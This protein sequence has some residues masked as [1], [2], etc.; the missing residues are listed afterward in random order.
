MPSYT[1][2]AQTAVVV[3]V[4]GVHNFLRRNR[5]LDEALRKADE[6]Y[7]DEVKVDL[8]DE[9]DKTAVEEDGVSD[10]NVTWHQSR[11]YIAHIVR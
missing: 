3:A 5:Q 11:D 8:L 1:F 10:D 9:D 7:D 2:R 6:V 4:M